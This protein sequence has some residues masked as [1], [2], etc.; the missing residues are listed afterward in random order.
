MV[1][2]AVLELTPRGEKENPSVIEKAVQR[3]FPGV[4]VYIPATETQIGDDQVVHYLMRGYVFV[5]DYPSKTLK[6]YQRLADTKY[7]NSVLS[8]GSRPATVDSSY[9]E[10]MREQVRAEVNQGIG[11]GDTVEICSGPYKSIEATVLVDLPETKEVQVFVQLRSKQ[12]LLTLPRSVLRVIDRGPLSPLFA[13]LGYL[14]AWANLAGVLLRYDPPQDRLLKTFD[15][16]SRVSRWLCDGARLFAFLNAESLDRRL[17]ILDQKHDHLVRVD[18]WVRR[19]SLLFAF[20][21]Y[22]QEASDRRLASLRQKFLEVAWLDTVEDRLQRI[23][24]DVEAISREGARSRKNDK[25]MTFQ[26]VL[27]DGHNLAH[28]CFHA[29]GVSLLTDGKGRCTGVVTGFLR[30]LGSLRK[31]FPEAKLWVAWDGS[32]ERRR[33][34]YGAYKD[35][36]KTARFPEQLD[37]LKSILPRLGVRQV[38]NPRE[39]A[40]DIIGTLVRGQLAT[41][42]NLI[43]STDRDFMQ[44]VGDTTLLLVPSIGARREIFYDPSTVE[45]AMGVP[46]EK[47][48]QLRAFFGD[49]SDNLPGVSRV[50]KR[51]LKALLKSHG[52]VNGVYSSGLAGLTRGQYERLRV[53]ESQVRINLDLM[54]LVAVEVTLIDPDVDVEAAGRLL[55]EYD[56]D[57]SPIAEAFFGRKDEASGE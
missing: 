2:W 30:G 13:R 31:R 46:P 18:S 33:A 6:S 35:G 53:A 7:I 32:S 15:T 3:V 17:M 41:E 42:R 24:R 9:I 52:S 37:L 12:A 47:V 44:L 50:P 16:Y 57:P 20:V 4:E 48:V 56:I 38:W 51:V 40:D 23:S 34:A 39:E 28:R 29:P 25:A 26:N 54:T 27:V 49:S 19:G 11:V 36:R 5:K 8:K 43:Y 45:R 55:Q 1:S 21:A 10:E 22:Q 14:R